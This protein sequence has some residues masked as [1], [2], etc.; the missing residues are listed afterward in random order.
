MIKEGKLGA[1]EMISLVTAAISSK[2][3]F[4]SP[5]F[6]TR[7]VGTAGWYMTLISNITAM[8]AFAFTYLLLKRFPGKGIV[9][10]FD[11]SFGRIIG[12]ICSL[13]MGIAFLINTSVFLREFAE[14]IKIYVYPETP[15][16]LLMIPAVISAAIAASLGL[17]SIAR[18]S[19][20]SAYTSIIGFLTLLILTSQNFK[21]HYIFPVLGYGL[22]KTVSIGIE[23]SSVYAE[24]II[25]AVYAG[26]IQ[27]I[28]DIKKVG[29]ISLILSGF[30]ISLGLLSISMAFPYQIAQ[31]ITAPVYELTRLIKYGSFVQR[32]DPFF[33]FL[34]NITTVITICIL[35]NSS[36]SVCCKAFRLQDA[37]PVIVPMA[38]I[39]FSYA[40]IPESFMSVVT[41]Y[42]Q[43]SRIYGSLVFFGLP[44]IALAAAKIRK[45]KGD[46]SNA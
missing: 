4:T 8:A 12:F 37:R 28:S 32:L 10:I 2:L 30:I 34:W 11:I 5:G 33:L 40:F 31:E 43:S 38:V 7:F 41:K 20:L 19:K 6:L 15:I 21:Y 26:S 16:S 9:E 22:S 29:F 23:R 13:T 3:F 18:F 45:K 36:V 14:V 42:V 25:L 1:Q 17:E 46:V 35:F 24:V 39:L 27:K 44:I